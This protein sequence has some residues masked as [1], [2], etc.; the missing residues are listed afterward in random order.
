MSLLIG[1][2]DFDTPEPIRRAAIDAIEG[3]Q[4]RYTQTAGTLALRQAIAAKFQRENGLHYE[5]R[6]IIVTVGA[7]HAIFNA[8]SVSV[9]PGDEVIVP[10]PYWV[11]YPDMVL[12][13]DGM[14]VTVACSE[15]D[16]VLEL[17]DEHRIARYL[18]A[19]H[20]VRLQAIGLPMAQDGARCHSQFGGELA[21]APL[22]YRFRLGLCGQPHQFGHIDLHR[23]RAPRQ[24]SCR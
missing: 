6:D 4:T 23:R 14:P 2:P 5:P 1:E 21:R 19:A 24:I 18:E 12:A 9:E 11:S 16:D 20:D 17:L 10:A 13:C 8:L 15:E 22:R 3:G 7:K